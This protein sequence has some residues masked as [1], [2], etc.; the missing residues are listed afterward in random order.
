LIIENFGIFLDDFREFGMDILK[1]IFKVDDN[2]IL[3]L[4]KIWVI[5]I[6]IEILKK[7]T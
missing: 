1:D 6:I 4:L 7:R 3:L 2:L 5:N